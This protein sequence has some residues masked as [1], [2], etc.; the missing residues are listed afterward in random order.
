MKRMTGAGW[1]TGRGANVSRITKGTFVFLCQ[2][3]FVNFK[4]GRNTHP[5]KMARHTNEQV[6]IKKESISRRDRLWRK[7]MFLCVGS[8]CIMKIQSRVYACMW[9]VVSSFALS[10]WAQ[11]SFLATLGAVVLLKIEIVYWR[12]SPIDAISDPRI[13][14]QLDCWAECQKGLQNA[15]MHHEKYSKVIVGSTFRHKIMSRYKH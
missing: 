6:S 10:S 12:V 7:R 4:V 14:D 11:W 1:K 9:N 2:L 13:V 5:R 3:C 8:C 15:V